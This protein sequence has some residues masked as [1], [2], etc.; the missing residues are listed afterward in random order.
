MEK[1]TKEQE[2]RSREALK[3]AEDFY[4]QMVEKNLQ[5]L[6]AMLISSFLNKLVESRGNQKLSEMYLNHIFTK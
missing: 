5:Q 6:D 2:E 3:V 4:D 1:L